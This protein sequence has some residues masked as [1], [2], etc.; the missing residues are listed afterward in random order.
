MGS[1]NSVVSRLKEAVPNIFIMKCICHS[2]H[3]CASYACEKLPQE[4]EKLTKDV[5]NYF[6][7]SPK[8]V[9][10]LKEFQEFANVSP[11]KILHPSA[12]SW[13]PLED[14]YRNSMLLLYFLPTNLIEMC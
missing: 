9:G 14:Y 6:S 3:L 10:E 2:F 5:Y 8:R 13:L 11:L 1:H 7:N 4:V 12:T